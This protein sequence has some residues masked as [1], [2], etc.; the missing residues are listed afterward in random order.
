MQ[1]LGII[2]GVGF[3][4]SYITKIFLEENYKVSST[5]IKNKNKYEHLLS[6]VCNY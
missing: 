5:D 6:V 3:I 4:G 2:G 1:T